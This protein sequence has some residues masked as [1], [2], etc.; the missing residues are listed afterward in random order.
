MNINSLNKANGGGSVFG[1]DVLKFVM[2]IFIVNI[3]LSPFMYAPDWLRSIVDTISALSVP[4]FFI[5]S[6]FLFFR[7]I[8]NEKF[9]YGKQLFHFCKRLIILYLFWCIVWSPVVYLQKEYLHDFNI[10]SIILLVKDFFFGSVF[11]ASWFL[12][13]LL[14]G[15]PF[16]YML[17]CCLKIRL[18]WIIPVCV[19][20]FMA[21]APNMYPDVWQTVNG[22]YTDHVC[23]GGM[24]LSFP[25]GLVYISLGYF[26][27]RQYV[28]NVFSQ[29]RSSHLWIITF[30]S[31]VVLDRYVPLL[32]P[33]ASSTLIFVAAYTWQLPQ[34]P[35]LY[36]RLRTYS[37]LFYVI[38]DCFKKIPKQLFGMQNGPVLFLITIAFCFLASELIIRLKD[39]KGFRWLKYAY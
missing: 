22:W 13:A 25:S 9:G 37:I 20:V 23:K 17:T 24:W 38:H 21:L 27:S 31:M 35:T 3:H 28:I 34:R 5:I 4:T 2:A 19:Y 11:D 26:L 16:V 10:L 14:V 29:W 18:F 39:L 32:E 33:I 6:S 36:K 1:L 30:I 7:K 12:G 8:P 15:V